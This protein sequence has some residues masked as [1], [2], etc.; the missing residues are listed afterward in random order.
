MA[1]DF[2]FPASGWTAT[3]P[4]SGDANPDGSTLK[5]SAPT[6]QSP[7]SGQRFANADNSDSNVIVALVAGNANPQYLTGVALTYRFE[8]YNGA[9]ARVFLSNPVP[10]GT[11][12]TS[13]AI[14]LNLEGLEGDQVYS[15][16]AR[17]EYQGQVGP[18]SP[19]TAFVE[20]PP[21]VAGYIRGNE[22]YDPLYT[23][24]SIGEISG[25]YEFVP[26]V[27]IRLLAQTS[28]VTYQLQQTL[29][30][31]EISA[32]VT[33]ITS[34]TPGVK[35]KIFSMSQGLEDITTNPRRFTV[36]KRGGSD[37]GAVAWR[38][39]TSDDQIETI[40]AE[41][42]THRFLFNNLYYWRATFGGDGRNG[43]F[44]LTVADGGVGGSV[45]YDY[46]KEYS[47]DYNPN[48]HMVFLGS[49]P[50]RSGPDNQTVP[51]MV[52]RQLWVSGRPRPAFATK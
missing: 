31:G 2:Q 33:N 12:A 48:P 9:G 17:A 8:L 21:I 37:A 23:G 40:G 52:I 18:W 11:T 4:A 47:G 44:N 3:S 51:N 45:F 32:L 43:A 49:P 13:I 14:P 36:E 28:Y 15:W 24:K 1:I 30:R 27:G 41:R 7:S 5:V 25:P 50:S 6:A 35:T 26:G 22:L 19:R 46:G 34:G 10:S 29:N 42:T 38:V 16:Q 20:V 39:I